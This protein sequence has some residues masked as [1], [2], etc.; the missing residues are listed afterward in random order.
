MWWVVTSTPSPSSALALMVSQSLARCSGSTPEVGSSRTSR[1][2]GGRARSRTRPAGAGR[3]AA[4]RRARHRPPPGPPPGPARRARRRRRPRRRGCRRRSGRRAGRGTGRRSRGAP[5][6]GATAA[7]RTAGPGEQG[8]ALVQD[9]HGGRPLG[10]VE[11]GGGQRHGGANGGRP[12]QQPPPRPSTPHP[13]AFTAHLPR[14]WRR[15]PRRG[16]GGAGPPVPGRAGSGRPP[17]RA[18]P[19]RARPACP[20]AAAGP[21]SVS[22]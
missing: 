21:R 9:E 13:P 2:G 7:R 18:R 8:A 10:L 20:A 6:C 11:V 22:P 19:G 16:V 5:G 17:G 14:R 12:G 15:R 4:R 1:P 3:G